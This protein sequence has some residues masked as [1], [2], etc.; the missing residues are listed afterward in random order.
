MEQSRSEPDH[1]GVKVPPPLI[2]LAGLLAGAVLEAI[3]PLDGLESPWRWVVLALGVIAFVL[4][5]APAMRRFLKAGTQLPP[6]RPT[7]AIVTDGPYRFTRNPMY[8]GM[9]LLYV[10]L[11]IGL[12]LIWALIFLPAILLV[13]RFHV[14]AREERYLEAKFGEEYLGYKREVRRWV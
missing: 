1:A 3:A 11:A 14:I 8:V 9:T 7:T 13:I 4:L 6:F 10:G 2:Y 5:D 12:D